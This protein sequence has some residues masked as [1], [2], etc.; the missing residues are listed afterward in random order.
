[1][2]NPMPA[3][4]IRIPEEAYPGLAEFILLNDD[5]FRILL[6]GIKATEPTFYPSKFAV[7][8]SKRS[9][10]SIDV[11]E[12]IIDFVVPLFALRYDM[13]AS[14]S[15]F[16]DIFVAAMTRSSFDLELPD[17]A[18][19]VITTRLPEILSLEPSLGIVSKARNVTFRHER[20]LVD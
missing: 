10:L 12:G 4:E 8:V 6:E 17:N 20:T 13:G 16:I 7:A 15:R 2:R 19:D 14:V 5:E 9:S 11:V 3:F 1:M 18:K